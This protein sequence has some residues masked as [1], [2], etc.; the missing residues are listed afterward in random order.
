MN[1]LILNGAPPNG[2]G[3]AARAAA[4]A[5]ERSAR[6]RGLEIARFD[7]GGLDIGP[8]RGCFAC[9]LKHPGTCAFQDDQASVLKAMAACD[10]Q[11]W[12]T[13]IAFGGYGP[14]LKRALDRLIPNAL[15]FFIRSHSEV[16][17][18]L[19]YEKRQSYLVL[20]TLPAPEPE[21]EGIFHRLVQRNTLNLGAVLTESRVL[22]EGAD[23]AGTDCMIDG[24][25]V[26]AEEAR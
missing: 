17:H 25:I 18:P 22:Y 19:R 10:T 21:S 26:A 2:R 14:A 20:G 11:V 9:W 1:V 13:P 6:A 3:T 8:C 24:L 16:H 15:P 12:I 4:D 7:L 5:A 23:R